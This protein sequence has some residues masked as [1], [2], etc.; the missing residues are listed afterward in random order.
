MMAYFLLFSLLLSAPPHQCFSGEAPYTFFNDVKDAEK[1]RLA[2]GD[3]LR[4]LHSFPAWSD[5]EENVHDALPL[6]MRYWRGR[7]VEFRQLLIWMW[8]ELESLRALPPAPPLPTNLPPP[9]PPPE[10]LLAS[11]SLVEDYP[12]LLANGTL[13]HVRG[14]VRLGV[15]AHEQAV[16]L[17][18][19]I[20]RATPGLELCSSA[21]QYSNIL[22]KAT[23]QLNHRQLSLLQRLMREAGLFLAANGVFSGAIEGHSANYL[24]KLRSRSGST[25]RK[26]KR[27]SLARSWASTRQD[28]GANGTPETQLLCS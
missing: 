7:F 24:R 8:P 19:E 11:D 10:E 21:L 12:F 5:H 27:G 13:A 6:L 25:D 14:A 26:T 23:T 4:L 22:D 1:D 16:A 20:C 17:L 2:E 9:R 28:C 15:T 18:D 3:V